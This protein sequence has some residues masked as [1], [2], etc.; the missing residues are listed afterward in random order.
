MAPGRNGMNPNLGLVYRS[1]SGN[2]WMGVGWMLK[3]GRGAI[4]QST[5][6]GVDYAA[7]QYVF[8]MAGR[9]SDLWR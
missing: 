1:G 6:F 7:N 3:F 9:T 4:E 5:K 8:Q 2:G